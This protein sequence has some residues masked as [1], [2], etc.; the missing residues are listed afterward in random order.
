MLWPLI[1][2]AA[3]WMF[4]LALYLLL[5]RRETFWQL[6]RLYLLGAL[7]GGLLLPLLPL[8]P[9]DKAHPVFLQP[10]QASI[11]QLLEPFAPQQMTADR[12]LTFQWSLTLIYA[13]GFFSA[14]RSS[15]SGFRQIQW[16][17]KNGKTSTY[18]QFTLIKSPAVNTPFSFWRYIFIPQQNAA[19]PQQQRW[20]L[21]HEAEHLRR[22]HSLDMLFVE[23]LMI[24]LWFFHPILKTYQK[25]LS[26]LHEY[27]AD[28]ATLRFANKKE[29]GLMLLQ[30]CPQTTMA[31]TLYTHP[32][33]SNLKNRFIMMSKPKS[34][35]SALIKYAFSLPLLM[36]LFFLFNPATNHAQTT[37][38]KAYKSAENMPRFPG[39]EHLESEEEK[40]KCAQSEMLKFIYSNIKYPK[41]AMKKGIEGT[42]VIGF[43]VEKD[44]TITNTKIIRDIGGGCAEEALRIVQMMPL[45]I[46]GVQ[47]GK[48]VR[49]EFYLPIKF[50][51]KEE[52]KK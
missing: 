38:E 40:N 43:V 12:F 28:A 17:L 8:L 48:K 46:P 15:V 31:A 26:L 5:L 6:N 4:A 25:Q 39:C 37:D 16:L 13:I 24:L 47:R 50:K 32:V 1:T 11:N 29:Y 21:I 42:V 30:A 44:G 49:V 19:S 33:F 14:L 45:W 52:N 27:Q 36:S 7:A 34:R 35:K 41:K 9:L 22:K 20:I 3:F 51:L 2:I 10:V 18:Q 23:L